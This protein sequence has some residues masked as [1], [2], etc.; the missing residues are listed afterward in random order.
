MFFIDLFS[1][2]REDVKSGVYVENL[3]EECVYT[4]ADVSKLLIKV[5]LV[6]LY[7]WHYFPQTIMISVC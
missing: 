7:H 6:Y 2:I 1:Q 5:G 3:K 4:M